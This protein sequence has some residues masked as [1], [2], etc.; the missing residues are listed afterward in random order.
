VRRDA[1]RPDPAEEDLLIP[2]DLDPSPNGRLQWLLTEL[3]PLVRRDVV[4]SVHVW[5]RPVAVI[6]API[7]R[8]ETRDDEIA[9]V[10]LDDSPQGTKVI[11]IADEV[12]SAEIDPYE[13]RDLRIVLLGGM[14]IIRDQSPVARL[15]H[16]QRQ[17]E[18]ACAQGDPVARLGRLR[19][20]AAL[21]RADWEET[22]PGQIRDQL[23]VLL[24]EVKRLTSKGGFTPREPEPPEGD[25]LDDPDWS[26]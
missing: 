6:R 8:I 20:L 12:Q 2:D 24:G 13:Q 15:T 11:L 1:G 10:H 16:W 23:E 18:A 9:Y 14:V 26:W 25:D 5:D 4:V 21:V 19:L 3:A 17:I 7:D 22:P